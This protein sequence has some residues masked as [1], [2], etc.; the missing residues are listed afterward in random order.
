MKVIH[1]SHELLNFAL[2][3]QSSLLIIVKNQKAFIPNMNFK[4][5]YDSNQLHFFHVSPK[6]IFKKKKI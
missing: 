2:A 1:S 4:T 3:S 6:S 5:L